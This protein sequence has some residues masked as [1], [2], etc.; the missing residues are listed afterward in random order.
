MFTGIIQGV[1]T[2]L[3]IKKKIDFQILTIQFPLHL[4]SYLNIGAS[5]SNNGC[6]LTITKIQNNDIFFHVIHET[7]R[8][9][10]LG[11]LK[12]GSVVN[13]ER[14]LKFGDEVGG[15][16]MSGHI[17]GTAKI[18]NIINYNNNKKIFFQINNDHIMKYIFLKGFIG[19]DGISLTVSDIC[20]NVFCVYC[21]P[22]TIQSTNIKSKKIGEI[23]NIEVDYYTQIVVDK[24]QH[25]MCDNFIQKIFN[26]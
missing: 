25:Y 10:N 19:I 17:I 13:V 16:L 26:K 3:S 15:H 11:L 21:I 1:A 14:A 4:V 24:L 9:T 23:V 18:L 8:T 6:C 22:E 20:K 12:I 2:V 7:L 5:I